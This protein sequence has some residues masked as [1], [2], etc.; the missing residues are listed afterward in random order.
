MSGASFLAALQLGDSAL[1]IGRFVHS[2]GLEA[3]L[4]GHG[5]VE[6]ET[7]AELVEA[8]VCEAVAPLDGILVARAHAAEH[9]VT[10]RQLDA[11]ATARRLAP[12]SRAASQSCGRQLARLAPQLA[13]ADA[14]LARLCAAVSAGETDGNLPVVSGVLMRA[15][16]VA[17]MDA[18]LVELRGAAAALL[19]A[20]VRLGAISP[21]RSQV[22]LARMAP[23]LEQAAERALAG[24]PSRM[25]STAPELELYAMSHERAETRLFAT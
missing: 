21:V 5:D 9:L 20:A 12:S 4:R 1:P 17:A 25:S 10:L 19:S 2:Y 24:D 6:P 7:L 15:L 16:G 14:L 13:P 22:A 18:V 3:W 23:A 11:L 8:V